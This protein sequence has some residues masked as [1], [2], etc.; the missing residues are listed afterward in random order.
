MVINA[1][2]GPGRCRNCFGV[3]FLRVRAELVK[4]RDEK[5]LKLSLQMPNVTAGHIGT[6]PLFGPQGVYGTNRPGGPESPNPK[7]SV[8]D[9]A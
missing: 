6:Q 5:V 3:V 1:V 2:S 4:G 9:G 7:C 8:F